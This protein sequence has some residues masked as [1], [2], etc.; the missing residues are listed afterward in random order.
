LAPITH[1]ED[2]A[3]TR[4]L[5]DLGR[6]IEAAQAALG[7]ARP[8]PPAPAAPAHAEPE[9]RSRVWLVLVLVLV[10][11]IA[12][13]AGIGAL[14]GGDD[15]GTPVG[16][17]APV[18]DELVAPPLVETPAGTV[19]PDEVATPAPAA[20]EDAQPSESDDPEQSVVTPAG[21]VTTVVQGDSFWTIAEREVAAGLGTAPTDAQVAAY[22]AALLDANAD[23]LVEPGNPNLILPG[24]QL[25]L[26][27]AP[28]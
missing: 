12:G 15:D 5:D 19:A 17:E 2:A 24:Q 6:R 20:A 4:R 10:G 25:V 7:R 11:I 16:A 3:L 13:A 23:R 8:E 22:W 9:R 28:G 1:A 18:Q 26:V 21:Q 27:A 14:A